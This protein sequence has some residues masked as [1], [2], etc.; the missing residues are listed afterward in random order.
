MSFQVQQ[1][2]QDPRPATCLHSV[3]DV[4][5]GDEVLSYGEYGHLQVST[6]LPRR[7]ALPHG[8]PW[9]TVTSGVHR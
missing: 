7:P 2:K 5:T 1:F 3:F 6:R 8:G 9:S 4:R